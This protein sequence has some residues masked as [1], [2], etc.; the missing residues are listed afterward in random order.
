MRR[1]P[2]SATRCAT[3]TA[4]PGTCPRP[5]AV[6]TRRSPESL[7]SP[8]AAPAAPAAGRAAPPSWSGQRRCAAGSGLRPQAIAAVLGGK[9]IPCDTPQRFLA[10][11]LAVSQ[12]Y[13][14]ATWRE[15]ASQ[16]VARAREQGALG[17]LVVGLGVQAS[18]Q[19]AEG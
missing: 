4:G 11:R 7:S 16:W 1:W 13:D 6:P 2:R 10:F 15:L 9:P 8:R 12:L 19:A 18:S 17:I 5:R 14:D 3:R